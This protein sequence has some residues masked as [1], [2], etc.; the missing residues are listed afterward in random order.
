MI[1]YFWA[2]R[3]GKVWKI[4]IN[5]GFLKLNVGNHPDLVM[6]QNYNENIGF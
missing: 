3:L 4:W 6:D 2:E 5:A 1:F